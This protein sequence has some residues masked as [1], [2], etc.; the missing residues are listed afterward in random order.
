MKK[1]K[2]IKLYF[3]EDGSR[4]IKDYCRDNKVKFWN[5]WNHFQF[6]VA[7]AILTVVGVLVIVSIFAALGL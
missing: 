2:K 3:T 1:E 6:D 4:K 5:D 7:T